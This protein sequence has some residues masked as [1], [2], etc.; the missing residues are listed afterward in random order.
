[1]IHVTG[2]VALA[3][4]EPEDALCPRMASE[5]RLDNEPACPCCGGPGVAM[6]A[7]GL[8]FIVRCEKCGQQTGLE[9]CEA[10]AIHAWRGLAAVL[11][12]RTRQP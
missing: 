1:M 7:Y 11:K 3:A 10:D 8:A 12:R 9:R 6:T 5:Y 2:G 4:S